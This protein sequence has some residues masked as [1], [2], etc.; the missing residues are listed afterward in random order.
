VTRAVLL[1]VYGTLVEPDWPS[2]TAGRD[3]IADRAG[4]D[5]AAAH[6]AWSTTH[7]ARMRGAFGSL[8]ADLRAVLAAAAPDAEPVGDRLLAELAALEHAN[9]AAG[10]RLFPDTRPALEAL[11]SAGMRLAIVTNAS[12]EAAAVIPVLGL[13]VLVDLVVASCQVGAL[14]PELLSLTLDRLG[15]LPGDA[16]LVDDDPGEVAAARRIGM[17]AVLFDRRPGG[18]STGPD[19]TNGVTTTSLREVAEL[20][21]RTSSGPRG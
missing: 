4:I 13:D 19:T 3:A 18:A 8:E 21:L 10:V 15:L 17:D 9:W 7:R 2:L 14:K 1:D 16:T 5:R 6:D 12:A 11:R 20:M